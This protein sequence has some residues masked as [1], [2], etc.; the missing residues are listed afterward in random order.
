VGLAAQAV[1]AEPAAL[2]AAPSR[3]LPSAGGA[4][5][6]I[7]TMDD[8]RPGTNLALDQHSVYAGD[9][10]GLY[11]VPRSTGSPTMLASGL[12]LA[13]AVDAACVYFT[14]D[15]NNIFTLPK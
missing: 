15:A 7:S 6:V 12:T 13:V 8:F 5:T 1:R 3:P 2:V 10:R 11:R 14:D 9:L 4:D